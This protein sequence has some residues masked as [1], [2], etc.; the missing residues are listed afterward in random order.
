M[1][2]GFGA[3]TVPLTNGSGSGS[4]KNMRIP[5][6]NYTEKDGFRMGVAV[7]CNGKQ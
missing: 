6:K 1:K 3:G 4:P 5:G 7:H 2:K